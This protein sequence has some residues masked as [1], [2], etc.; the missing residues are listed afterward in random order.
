M[1]I[2]S[3]PITQ[4]PSHAIRPSGGGD[5]GVWQLEA[6]EDGE[7]WRVVN[8]NV[9]PVGSPRPAAG[10]FHHGERYYRLGW[11]PHGGGVILWQESG[12]VTDLI[13]T[14]AKRYR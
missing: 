13:P 2:R 8:A 1:V 11:V 3:F 4:V 6:S 7:T 5:I 14:P 12:E 10:R 9:I